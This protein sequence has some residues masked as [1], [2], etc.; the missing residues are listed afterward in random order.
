MKEEMLAK[1]EANQERMMARMDTQ[2]EKME[3]C[4][5]KTE[6]MNLDANPE[7]IVPE[8]EHE[9]VPKEEAAMKTVRARK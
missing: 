6:V 9:E 5:G 3:A 1:M 7:E 2:L 4:V 8:S